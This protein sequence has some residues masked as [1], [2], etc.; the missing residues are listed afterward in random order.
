MLSQVCN[1]TW[2]TL[3]EDPQREIPLQKISSISHRSSQGESSYLHHS[4]CDKQ[5][6]WT[7]SCF[8]S[9][10]CVMLQALSQHGGWHAVRGPDC[11]CQQPD[12]QRRLQLPEFSVFVRVCS[13]PDSAVPMQSC[14]SALTFSFMR[15][16]P[17]YRIEYPACWSPAHLPTMNL[18]PSPNKT[19]CTN[20]MQIHQN[21]EMYCISCESYCML[22]NLAWSAFRCSCQITHNDR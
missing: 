14:W 5:S 2:W 8:Y 7:T 17:E 9:S 18:K 19:F 12:S 13:G 10:L 3:S 15:T 16:L 1:L 6:S 4:S 21:H 22:S 20:F 11:A